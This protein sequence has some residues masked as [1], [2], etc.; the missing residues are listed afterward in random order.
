MTVYVDDVGIKATVRDDQ[1]GRTHTSSWC[2]LFSDQIDQT[3]LHDFAK[4]IGMQRRW[5][6]PGKR[7]GGGNDPSHDHYDLTAG[8]RQ[9]AIRAGAVPVDCDQAVEIWAA[10]RDA[11][12]AAESGSV[13]CRPERV[14]VDGEQVTVLARGRGPL[15]EQ[16]RQAMADFARLLQFQRCGASAERGRRCPTLM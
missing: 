10:K 2:H 8:K 3:E 13:R 4:R 6:Q 5:F 16:D 15:T 11:A 14:E 7:L 1:T 9:Q 12:R